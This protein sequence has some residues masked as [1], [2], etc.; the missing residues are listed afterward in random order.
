MKLRIGL[1]GA[2]GFGLIHLTGYSINSN[3]QLIS[4]S[5]RT[6]EHAKEAAEKFNIPHFYGGVD[7]WKKMLEKEDLDIVSIC[8]PNYLHAPMIIKALKKNL[9]IL[10][11]KPICISRDEL[12]EVKNTL[13]NKN[14]IF[15]TS[16][17]KRYNPQFKLIKKILDHKVLGD[18]TL[19]RYF[20]SHYGPYKSWNA[21]SEEKWFFDAEKAGGGVLL[22]LGVHCIDILRFLID[23]YKEVEG[24]N[25]NTSCIDM[26]HEDN[27]NVI[28]RFQNNTLG[29]ISVSWCNQPSEIIEIFG[30]K[31]S[32]KIDLHSPKKI[33]ICPLKLKIVPSIKKI[34]NYKPPH[35]AAQN[36]LIDHFVNCILN[37]K[38]ESPDFEDGKRAFEFVL[39]AYSFKEK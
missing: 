29:V 26:I 34:L 13:A 14:I 20:F 16:F 28:F 11:E 32:I 38:Q 30:T 21:L 1:I 19:V 2:G 4:V 31:G 25:Y 22:D 18:I 6:I 12:I 37:S 23:D 39:D 33:D 8:T 35:N 27:C 3:C 36:R 15:F 9:H 5:S 24:I 7:S 17:Q 10:C